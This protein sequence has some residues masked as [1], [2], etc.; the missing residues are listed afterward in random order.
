MEKSIRELEEIRKRLNAPL[1]PWQPNVKKPN[2]ALRGK[3]GITVKRPSVGPGGLLHHEGEQCV[4]YIKDTRRPLDTLMNDPFNSVRF[5]LVNCRTLEEMQ[6][7]DRFE[8]Y[9]VSQRMDGKFL[10]EGGSNSFGYS[11]TSDI[12][13]IEAKLLPCMNCLRKLQYNSF[14]YYWTEEQK[15]EA[16]FD[17]NLE[18]FFFSF[19]SYFH[20]L[21]KYS[22]QTAPQGGR[23]SDW[24]R[25]SRD[26][27][28]RANWECQ[29]CKV[30]LGGSR[31]H[32]RMLHTHHING[33]LYDNND[34]NLQA[35]CIVCHSEQPRHG[36]LKP[37][38]QT[39]RKIKQLREQQGLA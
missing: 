24:Q 13:E 21:P 6:Q 7:N 30:F 37:N 33:S 18:E 11:T 31:D 16:L 36:R 29:L 25:I 4:L 39:I 38:Q 28:E 19:D 20:V 27:R 9:V 34:S 17:F 5:H 14:A 1:M 15:E 23:P 32:K 8:R 26:F 3:G 22:D 2:E 35:L 10:V 12:I